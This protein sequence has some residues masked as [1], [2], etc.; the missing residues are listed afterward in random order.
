M[1]FTCQF[2]RFLTWFPI[3]DKIQGFGRDGDVTGR[4]QF[5]HPWNIPHLVE[6]IKGFSL[7]EKSFRNIATCQ[8]LKGGGGGSIPCTTVGGMT[9]RARPRVKFVILGYNLMIDKDGHQIDQF[10]YNKIHTW[11]HGRKHTKT[12][13]Y[14]LLSLK[15]ISFVLFPQLSLAAK[16]ELV[17]W[18]NYCDRLSQDW[19]KNSRLNKTEWSG[20]A[21]D[22][23]F[24][25]FYMIFKAIIL[26]KIMRR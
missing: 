8:K 10:R 24:K 11:F 13:Y 15:R 14:S 17:Y 1:L 26:P 23:N 9:L 16:Y 25:K 12:M 5:Q 18:W 4:E 7:K 3:L 20:L 22:R 21:R 6:K 2:W 19:T